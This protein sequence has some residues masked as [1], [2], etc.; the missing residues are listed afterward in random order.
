MKDVFRSIE[1]NRN[2]M[3]SPFG[4]FNYMSDQ[5]KG[6]NQPPLFKA[7][8]GGEIIRLTRDFEG[9]VVQNCF[10]ALVNERISIRSFS[11][12][13]MTLEQISFLLWS[14]Q[15]VK[16][17]SQDGYRT[18]RTVPSAGARHPFEVYIAAINIRGLSASL[19]HYLPNA[20]EMELWQREERLKDKVTAALS[21]QRWASEAGAVFIYSVIPYRG[22]WRY[23]TASHKVMLID[24]GHAAQNL[25]LSAHAVGCGA[26]AVG[27]Y[28]QNALDSLLGLDGRDEFCIYAVPVGVV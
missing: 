6:A 21:G 25:Y 12:E 8:G 9:V 1:E 5:Q 3:K 20:H 2:F 10:S 15:G 18:M 4:K 28:D 26:C 27:H 23:G 17:V 7:P 14:T 13:P 16:S 11:N 24:A 22:E 19:Y